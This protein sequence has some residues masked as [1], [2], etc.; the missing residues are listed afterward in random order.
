V[1]SAVQLLNEVNSNLETA[2]FLQNTIPKYKLIILVVNESKVP[3]VPY[4]EG[5]E[6][7]SVCVCIYIYIYIYINKTT[8]YRN[9]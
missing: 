1:T 9:K 4:I 8:E 2:Q 6:K 5:K 7:T 3:I